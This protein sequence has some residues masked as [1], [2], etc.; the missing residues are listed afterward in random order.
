MK[1]SK[2]AVCAIIKDESDNIME[3]IAYHR[4]I[5][6]SHFFLYDNFSSDNICDVLTKAINAGFVTLIHWP[7]KPGQIEAYD[8]FA[9]TAGKG[10]D[11]GVFIDADEYICLFKHASLSDYL[12]RFDDCSCVALQWR[13]F[14]P[15]GHAKRPSGLIIEN[16][17]LR[18]PD[19]EFP[20]HGHVKSIV[21]L[22]DYICAVDPH[23]FHVSG[24]IVDEHKSDVRF[25][26]SERHYSIQ[27]I[28]NHD[29]ACV[30]H[31]YT[32]SEEDWRRKVFR[33]FADHAADAPVSRSEALWEYMKDRATLLDNCMM[34]YAS[35]VK[36]ELKIIT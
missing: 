12:A 11:W 13:N 6:V 24:R 1:M 8:H 14:G 18:L 26:V 20:A 5:G 30:N 36:E 27:N 16:Y 17:N 22:R 29:E 19:D 7:R 21:R 10:F 15:S 28:L 35:A 9:N 34:R 33:G 4:L 31:Y 2:I 3:W 25:T 32:K 23:S